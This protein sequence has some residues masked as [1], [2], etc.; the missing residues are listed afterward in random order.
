MKRKRRTSKKKSVDTAQ[1]LPYREFGKLLRSLR[2]RMGMSQVDLAAHLDLHPSYVSRLEHGERR[3]S[4]QVLKALS[5]MT[6]YGLENLLVACGL[7]EE[8]GLEKEATYEKM[9]SLRNEVD[10]LRKRVGNLAQKQIIKDTPR[11]RGVKL[12]AV[13]IFDATPAGILLPKTEKKGKAVQTLQLP[14]KELKNHPDAFALAVTG[15]SMADA[16]I[17]EGDFVVVSPKAKV[18]SGDTAV[19]SLRDSGVSLKKVYFEKDKVMLQAANREHHPVL[20]NYPKDV[21]IIGKAVLVWRSL[22]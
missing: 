2:L 12:M 17:F 10:E 13:P 3:P 21:E 5:E 14:G 15:E 16:G 18:K 1:Q 4:P 6:G 11:G 19:V 9:V 20:L 7:T 8:S 22:R